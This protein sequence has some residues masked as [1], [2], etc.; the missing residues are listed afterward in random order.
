MRKAIQQLFEAAQ[1][2]EERRN[3]AEAVRLYHQAETLDPREHRLPT[4]RGNALWLADAPFQ[5]LRAQQRAITLAPHEAVPLRGLGNALRDLNR[6]EAAEAA[7]LRA[8]QLQDDPCTSWNR[9]QNLMGLERYAEAFAL[10]E[11]RWQ[12]PEASRYR[13]APYWQGWPL[14]RQLTVWTEQGFGDSF[15]FLRWIVPLAHWGLQLTLEVEPP[16]VPLLRQALAWLPHPPT[17]VAKEDPPPPITGPQGSLMS[18]PHLLGGAP[19]AETLTPKQGYLRLPSWHDPLPP[20]AQPRIGLVWAAG[21]KLDQPFTEREYWR[22][23]LPTAALDALLNGLRERGAWLSNLQF[24]PDRDQA[25][26]WPGCFDDELAPEADF[27]ASAAAI[28]RLDL[29]ISVDTASAHL[30]GAMGRP[31]WILLPWNADPRWLRQCSSSPWYPSL[32]LIRQPS[33]RDWSG[34]VSSVLERFSAWRAR[35]RA[36]PPSP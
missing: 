24:G 11:A 28:S 13:P 36:R 1:A 10:A 26:Q 15:Q 23:S 35:W 33:H 9:S 22:R 18:L 3:W 32:T 21:R 17:V 14:S 2:A 27:A 20:A 25:R 7:Y 12:L 6:Y 8:S 29:L 19:L 5:A 16:L 34:L 4:N 31:G 30:V